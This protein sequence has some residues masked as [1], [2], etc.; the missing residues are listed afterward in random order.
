MIYFITDLVVWPTNKLSYISDVKD[1]VPI[2]LPRIFGK[3]VF[4][5]GIE[6]MFE[7]W[8]CFESSV[9]FGDVDCDGE[10]FFMAT[11]EAE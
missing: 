10:T 7:F 3:R 11:R 1:S 6:K 2:I 5:A 8:V 9:A 4:W